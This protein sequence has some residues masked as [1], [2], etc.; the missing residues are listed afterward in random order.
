MK[1]C[2][3]GGYDCCML[4]S[5]LYLSGALANGWSRTVWVHRGLTVKRVR[6][7]ATSIRIGYR[8]SSRVV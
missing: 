1:Q 2:E 7:V 8:R 4:C 6:F 5:I 3:G